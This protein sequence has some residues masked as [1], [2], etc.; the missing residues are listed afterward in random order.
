[1]PVRLKLS[2]TTYR[3]PSGAVNGCE[4]WFSLHAPCGVGAPWLL[5]HRAL[6]VLTSLGVL[7]V[8]P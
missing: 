7:N 1:V 5:V 2:H 3:V 8:S 4:N 6:V